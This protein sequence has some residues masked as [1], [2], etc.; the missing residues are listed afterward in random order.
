MPIPLLTDADLDSY[1]YDLGLRP[2]HHVLVHSRLIS[3]G[4]VERGV[5]GVFAALQKA[6][7]PT[8]TLVFPSFNLYMPDGYI[9]DPQTTPPQG[10]GSLV[11]YV[12]N[13]GGWTR[14]AC[15]L[16]SHLGI[17]AKAHLLGEV[18]G[19]VS[20]GDGC[21]FQ[22]FHDHNFHM[23]MLGLAFNEG[24]SYM[25]YV[26]YLMDVPYREPL[27]LA[28][29]RMEKDGAVH[30]VEI[31]YFGRRRQDME[32]GN[33]GR[34]YL[35][36]YNA[37]EQEMTQQGLLTSKPCTFGYSTYMTIKDAHDCGVAML[38][39]DPYAMVSINPTGA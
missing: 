32:K 22:I 14:S 3:L 19:N 11:D 9:F 6:V 35:E 30:D 39:K 25:H 7:G 33:E 29:K 12:W 28:R 21:D 26:E 20:L 15:P 16:H 23:L 4:R 36:N 2:G 38:K 17:G 37:V 5:E 10:M 31:T 34:A 24:L 13:L 18:S 1:F 8:G 27:Q